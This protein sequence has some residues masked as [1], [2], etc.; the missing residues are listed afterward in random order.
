MGALLL[1]DSIRMA[2]APLVRRALS[3]VADVVDFADNGGD[4]A[5][6]LRR[7]PDWLSDA[8]TVD[9]VH[10]NCGLHDIK[11]AYGSSARQVPI[12]EYASNIRA[13]LRTLATKSNARVVWATSTPVLDDRHHAT[14]GFDR[15]NDDVLAYNAVAVRL[16]GD[17]GVPVNDLYRVIA[18]NDPTTCLG[19]DGVHMT[20]RGNALL[21][22]AVVAC[23]RE[24]F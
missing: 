4:S 9:L 18:D 2:Y 13:V 6:V 14:K 12:Q 10:L 8:G 15:F 16:A 3:G 22:E 7:L 23:I 20:D 19:P 11:R 5:N 21:A 24:R 17:A 1:G